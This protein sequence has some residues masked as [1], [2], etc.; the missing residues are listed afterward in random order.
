[1]ENSGLQT[2]SKIIE[3]KHFSVLNNQQKEKQKTFLKSL[4]F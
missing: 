4:K 3:N 1:M 2:L